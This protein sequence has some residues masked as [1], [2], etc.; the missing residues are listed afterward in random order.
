MIG[1]F[2]DP[3]SRTVEARELP[4]DVPYTVQLEAIYSRSPE[5]RAFRGD[6]AGRKRE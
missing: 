4:D 1:Y 2:I 3:Y 5:R 6:P